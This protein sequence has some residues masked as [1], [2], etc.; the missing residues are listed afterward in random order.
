[1]ITSFILQLSILIGI[2]A[3]FTS[4]IWCMNSGPF[5]GDLTN[6][7]ATVFLKKILKTFKAFRWRFPHSPSY[8]SVILFHVLC[9]RNPC[10]ME[11]S[12]I[13]ISWHP[14]F[15]DMDLHTFNSN[16]STYCM[17]RK[18]EKYVLY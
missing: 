15:I 8:K 5:Y 14:H 7:P 13:I 4:E 16:V 11:L 1:M 17:N 3:P 12:V 18:V 6:F 10:A 9:L 2:D